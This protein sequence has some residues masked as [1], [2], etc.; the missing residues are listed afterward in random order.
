MKFW[1]FLRTTELR[2]LSRRS[3]LNECQHDQSPRSGQ[4][5]ISLSEFSLKLRLQIVCSV[6]TKG[7]LLAEGH[8]SQML[9]INTLIHLFLRQKK[10]EPAV[11]QTHWQRTVPKW[12]FPS[13]QQVYYFR[14]GRSGL[15]RASPYLPLTQP[16]GQIL[17]AFV[18]VVQTFSLSNGIIPL[19]FPLIYIIFSSQGLQSSGYFS[20]KTYEPFLF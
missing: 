18:E 9:S 12:R 13:S 19:S 4:L 14:Q 1:A 3:I 20:R 11:V 15:V 6:K 5:E 2:F 10:Q 7:D 17:D 16:W 8:P